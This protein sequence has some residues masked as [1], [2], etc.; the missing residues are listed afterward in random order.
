MAT[1]ARLHNQRNKDTGIPWWQ[2]MLIMEA[3]KPIVSGTVGF[4][5]EGAKQLFLGRSGDKFID[6]QQG[7]D[8]VTLMNLNKQ[9]QKLKER[10]LEI[11]RNGEANTYEGALKSYRKNNKDQWIKKFGPL[12]YGTNAVSFKNYEDTV[13][14]DLKKMAREDVDAF[15]QAGFDYDAI[16]GDAGEL[17]RRIAAD[18]LW[19]GKSSGGRFFTKIKNWF[20]GKSTNDIINESTK[21]IILGDDYTNFKDDKDWANLLDASEKGLL[22]SDIKMLRSGN[23]IDRT[24]AL[25]NLRKATLEA[26]PELRAA[27]ERGL[28]Y[29]TQNT[30]KEIFTD[31]YN[32]EMT[33]AM[34]NNPAY[35][36]YLRM[37]DREKLVQQSINS[38][39]PD[40]TNEEMINFSQGFIRAA[41]SNS[42]I[43]KKLADN[44]ARFVD[45]KAMSKLVETVHKTRTQYTDGFF[46]IT[47]RDI[48]DSAV[49]MQKFMDSSD[50]NHVTEFNETRNKAEELL[51]TIAN[52]FTDDY[53]KAINEIREDGKAIPILKKNYIKEQIFGGYLNTQINNV[54]FV[55]EDLDEAIFRT[56]GIQDENV[57]SDYIKKQLLEYNGGDRIADISPDRQKK[58]RDTVDSMTALEAKELAEGYTVDHLVLKAQ[59]NNFEEINRLLEENPTRRNLDIATLDMITVANRLKTK[60]GHKHLNANTIKLIQEA[61]ASFAK[62]YLNLDKDN[63]KED[64]FVVNNLSG[65]MKGTVS[66]KKIRVGRVGSNIEKRIQS[67]NEDNQ[68][69]EETPKYKGTVAELKQVREQ[70]AKENPD[71]DTQ[72][73]SFKNKVI[74]IMGTSAYGNALMASRN[75]LLAKE[76]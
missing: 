68:K 10:R 73:Q 55:G 66:N 26:N 57:G 54:G 74:S 21:R 3:A 64:N 71:L 9:A 29:F 39:P 56:V 7:E 28:N 67:N 38:M 19:W 49:D 33:V 34:K 8:A 69:V 47:E 58:I 50:E 45:A 72:S 62:Q 44:P 37:A 30:Q 22:R 63:V 75:S 12:D 76:S 13:M 46:G 11:V 5:G 14:P 52:N 4:V 53:S 40:A 23:I 59:L 70:V 42:I 2:Q 15:E 17:K 35:A 65:Q 41:Y 6:S 24:N 27:A 36:D 51:K 25:G 31:T 48:G 60:A 1:S 18:N 43:P 32:K 20:Q 16:A 61:R